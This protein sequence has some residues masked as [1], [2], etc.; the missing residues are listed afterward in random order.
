M[1]NGLVLQIVLMVAAAAL[2]ACGDSQEDTCKSFC[3]MV[4]EC[5]TTGESATGESNLEM[6]CV[7]KCES[8]LSSGDNDSEAVSGDGD[9]YACGRHDDC[10]TFI[11]CYQEAQAGS[12]A[13][14]GDPDAV[15]LDELQSGDSD[16]PNGESS[17]G[18]CR[19]ICTCASC[20]TSIACPDNDCSGCE[21][22]C[23]NYCTDNPACGEL[24]SAEETC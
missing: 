12:A 19:C 17:T 9:I 24:V 13:G 5:L 20:S 16:T 7:D 23:S 4:R 10:E 18:A 22:T 11:A 14:G 15:N 8:R 2:P 6:A 3:R 21:E 1:K